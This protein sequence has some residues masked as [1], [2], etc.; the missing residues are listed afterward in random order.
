MKC[1][2][3][4]Q[5]G[6]RQRQELPQGRFEQGKSPLKKGAEARRP[7]GLCCESVSR[8]GDNPF[9][10]V[11][12]VLFPFIKGDFDGILLSRTLLFALMM[13]SCSGV[14]FAQTAQITGRITD[15]S[16]AVIHGANITVTHVDKGV[17]RDTTS[18]E[19][20]YYTV[21]LLQPGAYEM[22]IETAGFKPV[23]RSGITLRVEQVARIDF[24]LEVGEVHEKVAV[25]DEAPLLE[26][27]TSSVG[28]VV[29]N[30]RIVN[31]PLNQRNPYAL[32]YLV[33]GVTGNIGLL[34]SGQGN[35]VAVN[36]GR[37][38]STEFLLDG[39]PAAPP[40]VNPAQGF[41][42]VPSVDAV[43]EFKVQ[44]NNYSAEF[45]RSGS[46]II[47]LIYKSGTNELH[48]SVFEFLRN[49]VLDANG[50]QRN[51][52]RLDRV[53]FKRNQFGGSLGGPI[54]LPKRLF[55]PLGYDGHNKTFFFAAYEGLRERSAATLITTVPTEAMRRGD[56][57]QFRNSAGQ[58]I[59]IYDPT[60]TVRQGSGFVRQAFPGNI[61]PQSAIDPV[62]ARIVPFYPLPNGPGDPVTGL[63][64]YAASG[65]NITDN[66]SLDVKVDQN[67]SDRQRFFARYSR[68]N[69]TLRPPEFFPEEFLV[70]ARPNNL[71]DEPSH[72]FAFDHNLTV[73][74]TY[75]L[76]VRLGANRVLR[77]ID[78][79]SKG[80]DPTELGF[81]TYIRANADAL[82]FPRI[83]PSGYLAIGH[84]N[85][86]ISRNAFETHSL[87]VANT[88]VLPRHQ[89]K[90]GF[91]GRLLR[92]NTNEAG[93]TVGDYSF[94][95][96]F[97]Q[98]PNPLLATSTAGDGF[99]SFLLGLGGGTQ[100][101]FFKVVS[102]QNHY[103]GFYLADDWKVTSKL[104][105]NLGLRYE[106]ETPRTER[107]NRLNYFD[108]QA[109]SP[110]A[111]PSG[112]A[113]L[114]GGLVFAT[115]QDRSQFD[116]DKN[117]WSPRFGFAYQ[118]TSKTVVRGAYGLFYAPS[119]QSA[120]GTVG[121]NGFS[122]FTDWLSSLDGVTPNHYLRD[123]FPNG[124]IPISGSS[125][126]LLTG[127]GTLVAGPLRTTVT[128]YTEGWNFGIQQ[129]LPG[130]VL[131]EADYVGNRGLQ[132]NDGD[133]AQWLTLSQLGPEHLALG[134]QLLESVPN[135]FFGLIATGRNSPPTF[136]RRFLL[137][138]FPQFDGAFALTSTGGNS[139]YHSF[140]L[141]AE[142]RLSQGLAL[143]VAYTN[144]KLIEDASSS[145]AGGFGFGQSAVRQNIYDRRAE[146]SVSPNDISQRLVIS[147]VYE[148]PFGRGRSLG[149][150][151]NRVTDVLLGGWQINGITSFQKG[152]PLSVTAPN[153]CNCFNP[154][155]R[156]N[157]SGS[158]ELSG[159]IKDRLGRYFDIFANLAELREL[160]SAMFRSFLQMP[161][162]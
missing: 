31:L 106:L 114:T 75:L 41:A 65:T 80:F 137:R 19:E 58:Q 141:K 46:G 100:T 155:L 10:L 8:G 5:S 91:E 84:S 9:A 159:S 95:R 153:T 90:F 22:T 3:I 116:R 86:Q 130:G 68:R 40:L 39:I 57:S 25:T 50:W 97:S 117:N 37:G 26:S 1:Q 24:T 143:L 55:G 51:R 105:L 157:I 13:V 32:A 28:H 148:L 77:K 96:S 70:A 21:P 53:S 83:A 102:T 125:L 45:G 136:Q 122:S 126:G 35:V 85:G 48:G 109:P 152:Q 4:S 27:E 127:L 29:D 16:S 128:P 132:L 151:W 42:A 135:P 108:P 54:V 94:G 6:P 133:T 66:D 87:H 103:W 162:P 67:L 56:F 76:N 78:Q 107:F 115:E 156:P 147:Y 11:S 7:R 52:Q 2:L 131:I 149:R 59:V 36:G 144:A 38:G 142:K 23:T 145:N 49:S 79:P 17:K 124:F 89:L 160:A 88:K 34:A 134:S 20:G 73:S 33:P 112:I 113:N 101:K 129:E 62:A 140:Q 18:N 98:G 139:F 121:L 81:P 150:D 12:R 119:P 43:Q 99:A 71:I 111:G 118:A 92:V 93:Q 61:I 161:F 154:S 146:R 14:A 82:M 63:R 110:L 74:P 69:V 15:S 44:T 123:P 47:N 30:T 72:S 104:T 138:P 60:T 64:N 120:R 158:A